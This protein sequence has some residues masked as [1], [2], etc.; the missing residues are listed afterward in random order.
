MFTLHKLNLHVHNFLCELKDNHF[1]IK[2]VI[3]FGSYAQGNVHQ[4]SDIDLA[5]WADE[6]DEKTTNSEKLLSI[7]SKFYPIQP[8]LYHSDEHDDPFIELIEK[9]GRE[10]EF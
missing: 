4:N 1:H 5:I 2:K 10:I 6:F 9:T 8:K 7:I 3:L